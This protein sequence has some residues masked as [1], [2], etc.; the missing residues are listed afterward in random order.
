MTEQE[1]AILALKETRIWQEAQLGNCT[2]TRNRVLSVCGALQ[3]KQCF[4]NAAWN[5]TTRGG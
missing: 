1:V 2:S 3:I 5:A 4:V